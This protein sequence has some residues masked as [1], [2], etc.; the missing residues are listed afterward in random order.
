[1]AHVCADGYEEEMTGG[2]DECVAMLLVNASLKI[3]K[4]LSDEQILP[5]LG[6]VCR[7]AISVR[8]SGY[9]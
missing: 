5:F 2:V 9:C 1:M 4:M 6:E 7:H 8:S 3:R